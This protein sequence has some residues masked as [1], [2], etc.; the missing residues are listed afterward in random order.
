[1][2]ILDKLLSRHPE[3]DFWPWFEQNSMRLAEVSTGHERICGELVAR[4]H[5]V[6]KSLTFVFGPVRDG[7]RE[8]IVSADGIRDAF[9]AV[10]SL[11]AAAPDIPGWQIIAFRPATGTDVTIQMANCSLGPEDVWFHADRQDGKVGLTLYIRDMTPENEKLLCGAMFLLLDSAI[12]EYDVET[13]V[14][15]LRWLP[16]P[17]DPVAEGLKPFR[18][19]PDKVRMVA[20]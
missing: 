10:R 3:Q 2:G 15:S 4:L 7:R 8:F 19:L 1:M 20:G 14:G 12:G 9:P 11:V 17:I 13:K 16:L 18:D 5:R 6:H